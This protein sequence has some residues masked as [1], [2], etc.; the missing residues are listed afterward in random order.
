MAAQIPLGVYKI[1]AV[2][3]GDIPEPLYVAYKGVDNVVT[4]DVVNSSDAQKV[5]HTASTRL[6]LTNFQHPLIVGYIKWAE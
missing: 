6:S 2:L 4:L 3:P 5:R 1:R